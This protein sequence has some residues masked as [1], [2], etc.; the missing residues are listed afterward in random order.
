MPDFIPERDVNLRTWSTAFAQRL[1]ASGADYNISP[2][3]AADYAQLQEQFAVAL[4]TAIEPGT[5]SS[6]ATV[7][8]NTQRKLLKDETRRLAR[9]ARA[10]P[11]TGHQLFKLGLKP[12][13][14]AVRRIAVPRSHPEVQMR[15][16]GRRLLL[17]L[18]DAQHTLRRGKPRGV[19]GAV[20][21]SFVG[22]AAPELLSEWTISALAT[23]PQAVIQIGPPV[24]PGARIWVCARWLNPRL[25]AGPM[26]RPKSIHIGGGLVQD[27]Q[28]RLA[29]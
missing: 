9:I 24:P 5:N 28:L 7:A 4:R 16:D 3:E 14:K 13:R 12:Q 23:K 8:K 10:S 17:K 19:V 27:N 29:A 15:V 20:I 25:Q 18:R 22:S 2:Q 26:S 6:S 21:Y 1:L 11:A